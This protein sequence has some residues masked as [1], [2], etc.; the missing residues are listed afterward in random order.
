MRD[1]LIEL[2]CNIECKGEDFRNGGCALRKDERCIRID[3]LDMCMIGC[4]ADHLLANGVIV[5]PCKVGDT[6]WF[7]TFKKNATVCVGVQPHKID[8]IDISFVCDTKNLIE[9]HIH[10]WEI[11][12]TVFLTREEAEKALAERSGE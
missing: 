5:P 10:D 12:K 9:T 2:L 8:R 3:N 7:N 4:I 11:G 6:V 1:R